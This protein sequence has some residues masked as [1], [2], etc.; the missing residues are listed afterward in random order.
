MTSRPFVLVALR[1]LA[2]I[3]LSLSAKLQAR[4]DNVIEA[5]VLAEFKASKIDLDDAKSLA[6]ICSEA[7]E[8]AGSSACVVDYNAIAG[9]RLREGYLLANSPVKQ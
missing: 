5:F 6:S 2:R 8:E 1:E 9:G 4:I 7:L 3:Q